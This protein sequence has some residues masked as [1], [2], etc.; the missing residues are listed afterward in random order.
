MSMGAEKGKTT[1]L[2]VSSTFL[3][4]LNG[5]RSRTLIVLPNVNST[6]LKTVIWGKVTLPTILTHLAWSTDDLKQEWGSY[7]ALKLVFQ[8]KKTTT[9]KTYHTTSDFISQSK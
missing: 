6:N 1:C 5:E 7:A 2:F 8:T 4:N 9:K 3:I